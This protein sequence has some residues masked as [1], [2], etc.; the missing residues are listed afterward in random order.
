MVFFRCDNGTFSTC[1]NVSA[2]TAGEG[3]AFSSLVAILFTIVIVLILL[4]LI[5][6]AAIYVL[7]YTFLMTRK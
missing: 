2:A 1:I 3:G 4:T 5:F 6:G 7:R